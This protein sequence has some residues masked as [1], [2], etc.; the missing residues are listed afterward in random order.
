M[1]RDLKKRGKL[2]SVL[3]VL[4]M[5]VT[6]FPLGAGSALAAS[7]Y[8][9][10]TVPSVLDGV[11]QELGSVVV[12][13]DGG[14][15]KQGDSVNLMFPSDFVIGSIS[16]YDTVSGYAY[17]KDSAGNITVKA[18]V[19]YSLAGKINELTQIT[20]IALSQVSDEEFKLTVVGTP[21]PMNGTEPTD[22]SI[23]KLEFPRVYVD[24]GFD[25][26][27]KLTATTSSG[28]GFPTGSVVV[29]RVVTG[30]NKVELAATNIPSFSDNTIDDPI[31][32]R[33][34]EKKPSALDSGSESLKFKLPSDFEWIGDGLTVTRLWGDQI[35]YTTGTLSDTSNKPADPAQPA[36]GLEFTGFNDDELKVNLKV[37]DPQ[38]DIN[39]DGTPDGGWVLETADG[40]DG[41]YKET[42]F[43]IKINIAVVDEQDAQRGDVIISTT[44]SKSDLT[45]SELTIA[46]YGQYES[47]LEAM[48]APL[49][50]SGQIDA[51]IGKV[52]IKESIA[53]SLVEG[54]TIILT[55]PA[56][57]KWHKIDEDSDKGVSLEFA[58]FPGT[59]GRDAK[60]IVRGKSTSEGAELV[61]E[62]MEVALEPGSSGDLVIEASGTAG[63]SGS[64]VVAKVESP[65]TMEASATTEVKAG[66]VTEVGDLLV[67]EKYAGAIDDDKDLII[68]LPEGVK[69]VAAPKVEVV[70]GNIKFLSG[71][72]R[73]VGASN[74]DDNQLV[75]P[76]DTKSSVASTIK[77]SG[78]KIVADRSVPDGDVIAKVQGPAVAEVNDKTEVQ[79]EYE[80]DG[81]TLKVAGKEAFVV[82]SDYKIFPKTSTA[83]K[84]LIAKVVNPVPGE[85]GKKTASFVIGS[86]TYTV[87]DVQSTMDVVAYTKNGR[88]YLPM[89]Y[90]AYAL[91]IT[92]E[93]ILW[94]G[95][96][97]TFIGNGRVVQV[98][99]GS[100]IMSIN[101]A[102]I[103]MDVPTEVVNGR[104]MVPF[105]WVA[106]A[107]GAQVDW[108]EATR[109]VTMTL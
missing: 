100:M 46:E 30:A 3:L 70:E 101:G 85:T 23:I 75:I 59:D 42:A 49:L 9:A 38:K 53:G 87:N 107:F 58:G 24:S 45:P 6:L 1:A 86:N 65:V 68:D 67:K 102:P 10:L 27:I 71:D 74:T 32:I 43:E 48:D 73:T 88:T 26:D 36:I 99:P 64:V 91:G 81:T 89:R 28:S 72:I 90:A 109:T 5:L 15:L 95:R 35:V 51:R 93:N 69:F 55:L 18:F 13:I 50:Y 29:G 82:G 34:T 80:Y 7:E 52:V 19:P 104:I 56:N 60:W 84:A 17:L 2:I 92:P 12:E 20:D 61:L 106:Q 96:T 94:D 21:Q 4:T 16:G 41:T 66:E 25:G 83:A 57:A 97:A 105:R 77:I 11:W 79:K 22:A 33:V 47:T 37:W 40:R 62:D 44:G 78:I 63:V 108:D 8:R 31:K 98:I 103:T 76:V 54:R 14:T 39:N